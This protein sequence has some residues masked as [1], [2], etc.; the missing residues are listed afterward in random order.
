MAVER[1][2]VNGAGD[3]RDIGRGHVHPGPGKPV[4]Q[5]SH[6]TS[7]FTGFLGEGRSRALTEDVIVILHFEI[8]HDVM[9]HDIGPFPQKDDIIPV[10]GIWVRPDWVNDDRAIQAHC[11]LHVGMAVIPVGTALMQP[12][13]IGEGFAGRDSC[14][15]ETGYAVHI[16]WDTNAV[17]VDGCCFIQ[18][19]PNVQ[20]DRLALFPAQDGAGDTA[21]YAGRMHGLS[22][23]RDMRSADLQVPCIGRHCG[24][25]AGRRATFCF[26]LLR[27]G[28]Q[29][30]PG[31]KTCDEATTRQAACEAG[32]TVHMLKTGKRCR[33]TVASSDP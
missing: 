22:I 7:G 8:V 13:A 21:S 26:G 16:R 11:F 33:K 19:I 3:V 6:G 31:A 1:V 10:T 24:Q 14:K 30:G 2:G 5:R 20:S 12:E 18:R 32:K 17:P 15:A 27:Q 29:A 28:A 23:Q 25:A 9:G 4:F